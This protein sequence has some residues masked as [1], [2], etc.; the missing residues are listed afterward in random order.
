M[1]RKTFHSRILSTHLPSFFVSLFSSMSLTLNVV[2]RSGNSLGSFSLPKGSTVDELKRQFASKHRKYTFDRQYFTIGNDP[3]TR[4]VLQNG[5][6]LNEYKF[7][8]DFTVIFKDLGPQIGWKTVFHVEYFGPIL[9][10]SL[11]YF[12]PQFFYPGQTIQ[13]YTFT[14]KVAFACVIFHYLKRELETHFVHRFSAATM[15]LFNIFKNS[16]HYW[17]IGGISIAYF[18]YHPLFTETFSQGFVTAAAALFILC[19]FGNLY[20]HIILKNLRRPGTRERG[21]PR[22]FLFEFVSCAN[23]T[24]EIWAWTIFSVFTM[25]LTSWFFLAVSTAQIMAWSVKKHVALKK[26]FGDKAPKRKILFP[27]IW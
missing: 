19:E 12:F 21:V 20:C 27:F 4:Q 24:F 13:P 9:L 5:K 7:P 16:F 15:P 22:G 14:Q 25:T 3:K 17:I 11:V 8:S 26:E 2:S 18:L 6:L 10:H 23:Y 1:K